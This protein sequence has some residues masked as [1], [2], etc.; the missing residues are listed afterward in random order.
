[1]IIVT[2]MKAVREVWIETLRL[3]RELAKRYPGILSE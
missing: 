3:R 2:A 1:M